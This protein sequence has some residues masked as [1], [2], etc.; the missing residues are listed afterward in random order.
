M[1]CKYY[2]LFYLIY[3]LL[4]AGSG[5]MLDDVIQH[6][7]HDLTWCY[8]FER[9]VKGYKSIKTNQK[10]SEITYSKYES[11]LAFTIAKE[12]IE[13]DKD[14]LYPTQRVVLEVHKNLL[15]MD[16]RPG[17]NRGIEIIHFQ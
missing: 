3:E 7:P 10:Q 16:H 5:E 2:F 1:F 14:N 13:K 11:R 8:R 4:N 15:T 12:H 9:N 6:G 17:D